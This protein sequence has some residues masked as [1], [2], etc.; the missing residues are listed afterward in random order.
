[1]Y[2]ILIV[3]GKA[4]TREPDIELTTSSPAGMEE[5]ERPESVGLDTESS[6]TLI[7]VEEDTVVTPFPTVIVLRGRLPSTTQVV[8]AF[9]DPTEETEMMVS[10]EFVIDIVL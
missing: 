6:C 9:P 4:A 2:G 3:V 1:M 7:S 5:R 10:G 8:S